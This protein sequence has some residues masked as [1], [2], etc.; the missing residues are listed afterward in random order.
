MFGP[1]K[2]WSIDDLKTRRH[3]QKTETNRIGLREKVVIAIIDDQPFQ[4][5]TNLT[6]NNFRFKHFAD[7][8]D[9]LT[10]IKDHPIILCD[11]IGVGRSM[12]PFTQGAHLIKEIKNNYPDKYVIAYSGGSPNSNLTKTATELSD[13]FIKKDADV[14]T[15]LER[16]DVAITNV[17]D[18]II[19]WRR[20]RDFMN[21]K[22]DLSAH[23][24]AKLENAFVKTCMKGSVED[25]GELLKKETS[26]MGDNAAAKSVEKF[27]NS[28]IFDLTLLVT[29]AYLRT[30]D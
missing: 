15:W 8:T 17:T 4:P 6:N 1:F 26:K 3:F 7:L 23:Q 2:A 21:E 11:I 27:I 12:N 22:H 18:P 10:L 29:K 5:Q 13:D 20:F 25:P 28:P 30:H 24:L 14:D 16:L 19:V 9:D